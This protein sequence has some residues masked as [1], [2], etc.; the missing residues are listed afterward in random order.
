MSDRL[1]GLRGGRIF[2][3]LA[4]LFGAAWVP[5]W[6]LRYHGLLPPSGPLAG[7]AWHAHEMIFGYIAAVLAGF[8]ALADRGP[9]ILLLAALWLLARLLLLFGA[10]APLLGAAVDLA[11][12]PLLL[13]L[14]RPPLWTGRKFMMVGI[15]VVAGALTALNAW[16]HAAPEGAARPLAAA[17][18]AVVLLLVVVGGRLVPGHT[19]A[20]TRRGPGLRLEGLERA[21]AAVAGALVAATALGL[22]RAG[23]LAAAALCALQALRLWRWRDRAVLGDPLLWG[24]HLGF[25]WLVLGLALHAAAGLAAPSL[26][27]E[28]RHVILV[29]GAGVLTLAIMMRLARAQARRPQKGG[30]AEGAVLLLVSAAAFLR[31]LVPAVDPGLRAG[32]SAWAAGAWSAALL[33]ALAI[34]APM[35][36]RASGR[37]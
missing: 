33:L 4:L 3:P 24:L 6:V 32:T 2:F 20:A 7:P 13:L 17:A 29:G 9:R 16:A 23:G 30:A 1:R 28:A 37:G 31:G 26:L 15:M 18:D 22:L 8:A 27:N 12:L 10:G 14:R 21:G 19:R 36:A 25:G 11:F 34:C 5:L 35:L